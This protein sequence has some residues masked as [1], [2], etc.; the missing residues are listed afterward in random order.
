MHRVDMY[1]FVMVLHG[2]NYLEKKIINDGVWEPLTT[3]VFKQILKPGMVVVDIGANIG[4]FSLLSASIVGQS[5]QVH[6]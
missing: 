2:D 5:G 1:G 6:S 4:Y 3:Q